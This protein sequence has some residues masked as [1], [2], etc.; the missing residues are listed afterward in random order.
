IPGV[1][2]MGSILGRL[3]AYDS[4]TGVRLATFATQGPLASPAVV[5]DG[6]LYIGAGTGAREDAP[7][8]VAYVASLTPSPISAFCIAGT[9]GCSEIG[10]CNDGKPCGVAELRTDGTCV[11][12]AAPDG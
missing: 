3:V 9:D 11:K 4:A 1:V 7:E 12:S 5:V 10:R 2:F 6:Q 8:D